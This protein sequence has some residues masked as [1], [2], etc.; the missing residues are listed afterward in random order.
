M[1][2]TLFLLFIFL[3]FYQ[4]AAQKNTND[5][6]NPPVNIVDSLLKSDSMNYPFYE[7][8]ID[9]CLNNGNTADA[10]KLICHGVTINGPAL[11][12]YF[13]AAAFSIK[14]DTNY[15]SSLS[16]MD[17]IIDKNYCNSS[18]CKK[19]RH[20]YLDDQK[21][22][23]LLTY[24][25]EDELTPDSIRAFRFGYYS[26]LMGR[27]DSIN[28]IRLDSLLNDLGKSSFTLACDPIAIRSIFMIMTHADCNPDFQHKVIKKYKNEIIKTYGSF[29]YAFLYDR[30]LSNVHKTP[31]FFV[32]N[33]DNLPVDNS[34]KV[35]RLRRKINLN[36]L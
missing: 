17:S 28:I 15:C 18:Y 19:L 13:A 3:P 35:N 22:R 21:Y 20:M 23:K 6:S 25:M 10:L 11:Y 8:T 1:K 12:S 27:T 9:D 16:A 36:A 30:Y 29:G 2:H 33:P 26:G 5:F 7:Q 4:L 24:T 31:R 34:K 14:P 32:Y